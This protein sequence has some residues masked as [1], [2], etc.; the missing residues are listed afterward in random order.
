M[1]LRIL[2]YNIHKGFAFNNRRSVLSGIRT[3]LRKLNPDILF[4]QEVMGE[5][6]EQRFRI[7]EWETCAQFEYLADSYWSHCAYGK[8]A[9]YPQGHHGNAIL[10]RYP[11]VS[12]HNETISEHQ[13]EPRGLLRARV[14]IPETGQEV[15]LYNTHL[16]LRQIERN[17]QCEKIIKILSTEKQNPWVLV[18]DFNDWNKVL[19]S[20]L[21]E[22]LGTREVFEQL[23]G[24]LPRTFPSFLPV[25][26]LDRIYL[27]Q[28]A[29][30][31]A[32]RLTGPEWKR[33]SDHVPLYVELQ[34][35]G[36]SQDRR[37]AVGKV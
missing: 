33:L 24:K 13:A 37:E 28:A 19:A 18:G 15:S 23:H 4:L 35:L 8:N 32:E 11:I 26:P 36:P 7:P 31:V 2:T 21:E 20:K 14:M 12:W 34:I 5:S 3:A 27:H 1:R 9:I 25:L 10:S 22:R 6:S 30:I 29:P 16:D 17:K